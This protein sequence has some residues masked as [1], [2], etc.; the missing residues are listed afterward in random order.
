MQRKCQVLLTVESLALTRMIRECGMIWHDLSPAN[1]IIGN[2]NEV[3]ISVAR[4]DSARSCDDPN[5]IIGV[6]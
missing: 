3:E 6:R 4:D 2:T 5:F 1:Q